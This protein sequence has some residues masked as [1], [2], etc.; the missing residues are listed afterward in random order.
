VAE[1]P[2]GAEEML[3]RAQERAAEER[4]RTETLV[5]IAAALELILKE[6]I[7]FNESHP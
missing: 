7:A 2:A 3:R 4:I 5:R 1:H 6:L